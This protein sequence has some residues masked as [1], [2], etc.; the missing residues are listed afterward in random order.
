MIAARMWSKV[1]RLFTRTRT[2]SLADS[3]PNSA[4]LSK[5]M[6]EQYVADAPLADP[7][8]DQFG[9]SHFASRIAQT[10]SERKDPSSIVITISGVY[11]EGKSTVLSFVQHELARHNDVVIVPFNPWRFT[12]EES[13]LVGFFKT[14]SAALNCRFRTVKE[15]VGNVIEDYGSI[16]SELI[17]FKYQDL[18]IAPAGAVSAIGKLLAA[19]P[20]EARKERLEGLLL[21]E[22]KRVVIIMDDIDR[23]ERSEVHAVFRLIKLTADFPYTTY[24]L[25]FD[26]ELVA[27]AIGERFGRGDV[28]AGRSYL[29]KIV[30]VPL[31]LPKATHEDLVTFCLQHVQKALDGTNQPL[32]ESQIREFQVNFHLYVAP[33]L[34]SP[35]AAKRYANAL[36]FAL[37]LLRGELNPVDLL[38]LE[39]LK[40]FYPATHEHLRD[41]PALYTGYHPYMELD[42]KKERQTRW[43]KQILEQS[44]L[45][46]G[47]LEN[48]QELLA[49]LFPQLGDLWRRGEYGHR[50]NGRWVTEQRVASHTYLIRYLSSS[51]P[52]SDYS[53][54][55]VETF[56][57]TLPQT[58]DEA[59]PLALQ[60]ALQPNTVSA[61]LDKIFPRIRSIEEASAARL[62]VAV[63]G[64]G[65][66]FGA[67]PGEIPFATPRH[68][69]AI[70]VRELVR[71][72]TTAEKRA[73]LAERV[74]RHGQF[75]PFLCWCWG[76][77]HA[78]NG[79]ED[80]GITRETLAEFARII[81]E[82]VATE[83]SQASLLESYPE[84][85]QDLLHMWAIHGNGNQARRYVESEVTS[86]PALATKILRQHFI[87]RCGPEQ[88]FQT[89][90]YDDLAQIVEPTVIYKELLRQDPSLADAS[91]ATEFME[92]DE[93]RLLRQFA[94]VHR[95]RV[96]PPAA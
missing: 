64:N 45:S 39:A 16:A 75:L 73:D 15:G 85:Y 50:D 79:E 78:D 51:V 93:Q 36:L 3:P 27:E 71:R 48:L 68:R 76:Y 69:A 83:A 30:Q 10:I 35:R 13:L 52:G 21:E 12:S 11:G 24:L 14:L 38:L 46:G 43:K 5:S 90:H 18:E 80:F 32:T 94:V 91:Y 96:N 40:V 34:E 23:L 86:S 67:S 87:K 88:N 92:F 9:R 29:E 42:G 84:D 31:H 17:R 41:S 62:A 77:L 4:E 8:A 55:E 89:K 44:G 47:E 61:F 53:D 54:R 1:K 7:K 59:A 20:I 57:A 81:A 70:L 95:E 72:Q 66:C 25:A 19:T 28:A 22:R 60:R 56:L 74:V 63:A 6:M 49:H 33:R 26:H 37:P 58:K 82:R 65:R 2:P